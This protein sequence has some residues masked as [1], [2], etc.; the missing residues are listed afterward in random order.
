MAVKRH[1][2]HDQPSNDEHF[3]LTNEATCLHFVT[4]S[5][6]TNVLNITHLTCNIKA[7]PTPKLDATALFSLHLKLEKINTPA[8]HYTSTPY[9]DALFFTVRTPSE[10]RIPKALT[11]A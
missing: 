3:S 7:A 11:P 2:T 5:A 8:V 6:Q 9:L 4:Q 10:G 1:T